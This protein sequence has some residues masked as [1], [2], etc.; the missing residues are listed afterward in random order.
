MVCFLHEKARK[1]TIF[2]PYTQIFIGFF[3]FLFH[4]TL[5]LAHFL[6][7]LSNKNDKV[8]SIFAFF[9]KKPYLCAFFAT[10]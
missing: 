3:P 1:G 9:K 6:F 5:F 10:P 4:K 7:F 8:Q 2:F